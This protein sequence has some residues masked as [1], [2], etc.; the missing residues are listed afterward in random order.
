MNSVVTA[1]YFGISLVY[2]F[3]VLSKD[4]VLENLAKSWRK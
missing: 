2:T 1:I 4:D 3:D